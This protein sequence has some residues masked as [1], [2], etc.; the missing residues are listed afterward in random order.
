MFKC[1]LGVPDQVTGIKLEYRDDSNCA[2]LSWEEPFNN[3]NPTTNYTVTCYTGDGATSCSGC[4]DFNAT[5][6]YCAISDFSPT[7]NYTFYIRATNYIGIGEPAVI[8][9]DA[10][11]Y[12][13]VIKR[14]YSK[15]LQPIV[16]SK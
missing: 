15:T 12:M 3:F 13:Y 16:L 10:G 14:E 6:R 1:L 4:D 11:V 9:H 2:K 5:M 7:K 8:R